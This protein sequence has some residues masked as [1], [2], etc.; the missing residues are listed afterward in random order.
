MKVLKAR[1]YILEQQKRNEGDPPAREE[2][3]STIDL[4]HV[5]N[6]VLRFH[7]GQ[8][9]PELP[10]GLGS[11]L[12]NVSAT[13][14]VRVSSGVPYTPQVNFSGS[15]RLERNSG[16]SPTNMTVN[17][18]FSKDWRMAN[19]R[20]GLFF[21]VF[22]LFDR[23]NCLQVYP[24]TGRCDSGAITHARLQQ[25]SAGPAAENTISQIWDR[26]FMVADPR[27]INAGL[28]VSF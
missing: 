14:V 7:V 8:D 12:R 24:S 2:I 26:P 25:I 23:E 27:S 21:N 17:L 11:L 3:R 20:Y 1:L 5:F 13:A 6:G 10:L 4:P 19:L 18:Y 22:N 15:Q 28:R 16:T 9:T